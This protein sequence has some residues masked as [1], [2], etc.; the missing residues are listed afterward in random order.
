LSQVGIY[1]LM[2]AGII[3]KGNKNSEEFFF[4]F[5]VTAASGPGSPHSRGF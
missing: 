5:G 3:F 2:W 1:A 4:V